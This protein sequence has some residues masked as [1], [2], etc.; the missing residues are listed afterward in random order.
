MKDMMM[1]R[2]V[3]A[4]PAVVALALG[5]ALLTTGAAH[6]AEDTLTVTSPTPDA[7]LT[8]R[9]VLFSGTGSD[10]STVNVLDDDGDRVP[11]T[12]AAV[13]VDGTWE[14]TGIYEE[15][16][17]VSQTVMINQ[18]TGGSGAGEETVTFT[19]PPAYNFAVLTPA[20]GQTVLARTVVFGGTGTDGST[21]NV[22]DED[23]NRVPGTEAAVVTDGVW[24]TTGTYTE[25]DE[26]DQ[27]VSVNQVTGGAGRGEQTVSFK[28]P[29]TL[30]PAPVI[31]APKAGQALTGPAVTFSGTG[32]P[33]ENVVLAVAPTALVN[34]PQSLT[35][36]MPAD[37]EDPILVGSDGT[38]T[39]TLALDPE[40]YT[41]VAVLVELSEDGSLITVRSD[42]SD[43]VQ[44]TLAAAPA[45]APT[46]VTP[47]KPAASGGDKL[48]ET[49]LELNALGLGGVLALAGVVLLVVRRKARLS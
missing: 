16:A 14:T 33:G 22:L 12:E 47:A 26:I 23:G 42:V 40:D 39:V 37:P 21:V 46:P 1:W 24:A 43:P 31:L 4:V 48:A 38:W 8:S 28:L 3:L 45:P 10:G 2:K 15:S 27:T 44:F 11:G 25:D 6:A 9:T 34:Q 36:E 35:Q 18:V 17:D 49:G 19:L 30:L 20:E 13:V 5:G 41:A 29:P 32:T 7:A